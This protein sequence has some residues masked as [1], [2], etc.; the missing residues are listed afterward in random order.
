MVDA[1]A[2]DVVEVVAAK[3]KEPVKLGQNVLAAHNAVEADVADPKKAQNALHVPK[4]VAVLGVTLT[5]T[6]LSSWTSQK[7]ENDLVVEDVINV[8]IQMILARALIANL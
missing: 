6:T 5:E 4:A 1:G 8:L 2:D 7:V 3:V